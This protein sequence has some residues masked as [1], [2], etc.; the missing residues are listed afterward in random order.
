MPNTALN[1]SGV[2]VMTNKSGGSRAQGDVV[3]LD[4]STAGSFTT[5][6]SANYEDD[7]VGVVLEPNGIAN[8]ATGLVAVSGHVPKINLAGS[9]SLGDYAYTHTVAGQAQRSGTKSA[10]AFAQVLATGTTP[11]A[12]LFGGLPNQTAGG[13]VP[14]LVSDKKKITAGNKTGLTGTTFAVIDT[15]LNITLTT[16]ARRCLV[17]WTLA[18][19]NSSASANN[20]VDVEIDS[21]RV[22]G[23]HGLITLYSPGVNGN[24]N[25]SGTFLT[26]TLSAASHTFKLM[27]RVDAGTVTLFAS[28]TVCPI[29]F[30]VAELL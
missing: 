26:D 18:G 28:T 6:T 8:N 17:S 12:I 4:S 24:F 29:I 22:G 1:R 11:A 30:S 10:G 9:A 19:F 2:E 15:G 3:I 14:T 27:F 16:G 5:T 23:T 25:L 21:A 7:I 20:A 13:S